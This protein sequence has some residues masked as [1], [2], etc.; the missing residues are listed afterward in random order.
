MG[1]AIRSTIAIIKICNRDYDNFYHNL[2]HN[3]TISIT[4]YSCR[5]FTLM[6]SKSFYKGGDYMRGLSF[7]G[8]IFTSI[9]AKN[10]TKDKAL[11]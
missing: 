1:I 8:N 11:Y 6:K 9:C 7:R 10:I 2:Y 5:T 4:R 3:L